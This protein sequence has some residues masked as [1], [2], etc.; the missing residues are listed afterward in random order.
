MPPAFFALVIFEVGY[1]FMP[2]LAWI[3]ILLFVLL[4]ISGMTGVYHCIQSLVE[5]EHHEIFCWD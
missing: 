4:Y 5:M 1:H 2:W 3:M